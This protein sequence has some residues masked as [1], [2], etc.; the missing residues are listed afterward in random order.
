MLVVL[1]LERS[2]VQMGVAQHHPKVSVP[3]NPLQVR[4]VAA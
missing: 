4:Y 2:C 3:Q 1:L